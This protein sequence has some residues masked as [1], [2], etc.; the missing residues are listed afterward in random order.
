MTVERVCFRIPQDICIYANLIFVCDSGNASIRIIDISRLVSR[1]KNDTLFYEASES[2]DQ[3]DTIPIARKYTITC[4]LSLSLQLLRP[5]LICIG[6]K[7]LKDYPDFYVAD[8]TQG[9]VFKLTDVTVNTSCKGRL[10]KL[11]PG[12]NSDDRIVPVALTC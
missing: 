9:V 2:E 4:T 5:F 11:Y 6:R 8:T 10:Q 1:K 7:L 12:P 3:D